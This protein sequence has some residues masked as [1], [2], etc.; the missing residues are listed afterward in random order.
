VIDPKH[1]QP[2][3]KNLVKLV[4]LQISSDPKLQE[5]RTLVRA[6][7]GDDNSCTV[8]TLP[9]RKPDS[10]N[11]L[12]VIDAVGWHT[13]EGE[14]YVLPSL[15]ELTAPLAGIMSV[16]AAHGTVADDELAAS[17]C[18]GKN[19]GKALNDAT[20]R[21]PVTEAAEKAPNGDGKQKGE[22]H[23]AHLAMCEASGII[24]PLGWVLAEHTRAQFDDI[25]KN[26]GNP[27]E[28]KALK[29]AL[30]SLEPGLSASGAKP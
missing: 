16:R 24:P 26:C 15:N 17:I 8:T 22:A 1:G 13:N 10:P 11:Y 3:H 6:Q 30:G 21:L 12:E 20:R 29:A 4:I 9:P 5:N 27:E 2:N 14:Y 25:L 23:F 28:L 19:E 7:L 18:Q